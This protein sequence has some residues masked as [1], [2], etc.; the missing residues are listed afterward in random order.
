[1]NKRKPLVLGAIS[2]IFPYQKGVWW[3]ACMHLF[4]H[5][6]PSFNACEERRKKYNKIYPTPPPPLQIL[7]ITYH[8]A[9]QDAVIFSLICVIFKPS[10]KLFFAGI[11]HYSWTGCLWCDWKKL[12]YGYWG[13]FL[14]LYYIFREIA[15]QM[16]NCEISARFFAIYFWMYAIS[17][18]VYHT[19]ARCS[20]SVVSKNG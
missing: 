3:C 4:I 13:T 18:Y 16:A 1:M 14:S 17:N 2:L 8:L 12:Q 19:T 20:A 11:H 6:R 7:Y 15:Y 10:T 5:S 9:R